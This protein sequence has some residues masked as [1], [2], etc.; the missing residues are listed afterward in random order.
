MVHIVKLLF[1]LFLFFSCSTGVKNVNTFTVVNYHEVESGYNYSGE[2]IDYRGKRYKP[3]LSAQYRSDT[4]FSV[5]TFKSEGNVQYTNVDLNQDK[6]LKELLGIID[7]RTL[8]IE[9]SYLED[10]YTRVQIT[11]KKDKTIYCIK[12][13]ELV[14]YKF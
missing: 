11:E 2:V 8:N 3:V 5:E 6:P 14:I 13:K 10:N 4:L 12:G 9:D 7:K 1:F